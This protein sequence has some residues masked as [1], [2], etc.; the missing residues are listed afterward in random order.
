MSYIAANGV[1]YYYEVRGSGEPLLLLHGGLGSIEMVGE[2]RDKL[3]A[4][5]EV[6]AV[7]LH[8][9]GRTAL[10]DR[11][12]DYRAM[13]DDMATIIG[14]LG[15]RHV[16]AMGYSLGGG[17]VLRFAMQHPSAVRNLVVVSSA[18]SADAFFADL[19]PH[20][21]RLG[22]ELAEMMKPSP[23]YQTYAKIAPHPDQFGKLLDNMGALMRADWDWRDDVKAITARTLLVFGDNDSYRPESIVEL[24]KLLGGGQRDAGWNREHV[25]KNQLA[26]L[27]DVTHYDIFTSPLLVPIAER[28][29]SYSSPT[30][31]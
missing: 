28:F 24:Y 27:P 30:R 7:D 14:K 23:L 10:G 22:A 16:D 26:I 4:T 11:A 17:I 19:R 3:A 5:H 12:I 21:E 29:L 6:I 13:G 18:V 20:Q 31:K 8:G 9:H 2:A 15:F 1:D 25:A